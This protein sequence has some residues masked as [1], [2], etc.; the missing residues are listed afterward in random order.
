M[1]SSQKQ[2]I[3]MPIIDTLIPGYKYDSL[4]CHREK[5]KITRKG[6]FKYVEG[7]NLYIHCQLNMLIC[8]NLSEFLRGVLGSS[9]FSFPVQLFLHR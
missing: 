3:K 7:K 4:N 8:N 5:G 6:Y 1:P 2:I 9:E